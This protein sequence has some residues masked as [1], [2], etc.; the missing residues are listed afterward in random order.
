MDSNSCQQQLLVNNNNNNKVQF[1]TQLQWRPSAAVRSCSVSDA[2]ASSSSSPS[3]RAAVASSGATAAARAAAGVYV[4]SLSVD[5]GLA[6]AA[7]AATAAAGNKPGSTSAAA[8]DRARRVVSLRSGQTARIAR[9]FENAS[10][11][12]L[13]A[14][15][16]ERLPREEKSQVFRIGC[17]VSLRDHKLSGYFL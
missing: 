3:K 16:T 17:V 7:A 11:T 9:M 8:P 15:P 1:V 12:S 4:S 10:S 13:G 5:S 6:A 2:A 14:S